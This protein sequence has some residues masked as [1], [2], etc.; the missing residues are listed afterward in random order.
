MLRSGVPFGE[1]PLFVFLCFWHRLFPKKIKYTV[2]STILLVYGKVL[3]PHR[4]IAYLRV[5]RLPSTTKKAGFCPARNELEIQA[6]WLA[7]PMNRLSH[8]KSVG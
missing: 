7:L 6:Q 8:H 5:C 3:T 1:A 2:A 4:I